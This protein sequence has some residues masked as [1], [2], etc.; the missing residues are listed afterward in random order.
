MKRVLVLLLVVA[1]MPLTAL[2]ADVKLP[3]IFDNN[4][5]LQR[6]KPLAV[7]GWADAGEDVT[8][9]VAGQTK[10]TKANDAGKWRVDLA[11]LKSGGDPVEL[12]VKG[13]NEIKLTNVLV[14]EVWIC[15]GQSNMEW[16]VAASD[17][18]QEEIANAKHPNIRLYHI[19]KTPK[20]TPSDE[21][22]L[23]YTWCECSPETIARFTA[24]G[25]FFGRKL[26]EDLDVPVGLI[27]T[28]WGGTRIEP[29][30][31]PAGFDSVEAVKDVDQPLEEGKFNHQSPT[32]L[33]N[34]MVHAFV[35]FTVRGAIWYQGE[36]N[37]GEGM[38]YFEKMKALINGWR[39]VFENP[40]MPFLFVQLAPFKY[41]GSETALPEIWEAQTATLG[42]KNTGM[43]VTTD[44]TNLADIHPRNKQDVG[45]RLALWAL[46]GTYGKD[47]VYSGPLY[48][49]MKV[50]GSKVLLT[51]DHSE[52]LKSR[53]G[54]DLSWFTIAGEDGNFV[55]AKAT[56]DN[57]TVVVWSDAVSSPKAVRLGWHQLAE[58]NLVN[59]AGLPASP[60]R[61]DKPQ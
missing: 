28:S 14:G 58:P 33:Y 24:V 25:Y 41:N 45:Y 50:E 59:G 13:K 29:W 53:D 8:V 10:S 44:I 54:K 3:Q 1:A 32:A 17:N 61:T 30:T 18:P 35:P 48:K 31:P 5:V 16:P 37:R 40:E 20:A 56:I 6:E 42:V 46:A 60:F 11:P 21:L 23:E 22:V 43:A 55:E 4:M 38:L 49:S 15:S 7:W 52:G 57:D 39:T 36:S 27:N 51:F 12:V 47:L 2:Q 34:G 9:S 19:K 26:N